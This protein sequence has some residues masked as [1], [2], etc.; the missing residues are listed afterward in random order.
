VNEGLQR[1]LTLVIAPAG[2]GKTTLVADWARQA[3]LPVAWLS[4][5]PAERAPERFL[6]YLIQTLQSV[7][8]GLGQTS[9]AL[10]KG[11]SNEA[12]LLALLNDLAELEQD[13]AL[14]LDDYHSADSPEIAEIIRLLLESRPATLHLVL[15]TRA[16]PSF[17]LAR[18]R[19]LDQLVEIEASELRFSEAELSDFLEN[20]MGV[21]LPA[22]SMDQL[23]QSM[24]GWAAGI[25]LAALAMQGMQTELQLPAGQQHIFDYLAE[26]VIRREPPVVQDFLKKTALFERFCL[27]L[28]QAVI[29][30]S[31]VDGQTSSAAELLGHVE[32]ANLFLVPL[33]AGG[34]W[35]R[36]HALFAE[37]LQKQV[38]TKAATPLYHAASIWFEKNDLV[39]HAIHYAIHAGDFERAAELIEAHYRNIQQ[40]GE[41]TA[42]VEWL[43]ALPPEIMESHPK[44]WLAKG[45]A[46][47]ISMNSV[48]AEACAQ[49]ADALIPVGPEGEVLKGE[50]MALRIMAGIFGGKVAST[51]DISTALTHLAEQDEFLHSLL[52][53]NLSM[54]YVMLGETAL[55]IDAISE[56]LRLSQSLNNPLVSIVAQVQMGEVRQ[57][58]GALGMAERVFQQTM[59]YARETLGEHT[60]LLGLPYISYAELLREWNRFEEAARYAE[61]GI[62][63]C[64]VWQPP[65]SMDGQITLARLEAAQG[66]WDEAARRLEQAMQ[67]AESSIS[68]LDDTFVCVQLVRLELLRG[69]LIKGQRWIRQY[70]LDKDISGMYYHLYEMTQ[71]VLLRAVALGLDS[72][73]AP[74]LSLCERLTALIQEAERRE[75]VTPVIEAL[76][77]QTYAYH[78][79]ARH[80]EAAQSLSRALTLGAQCDYVRIFVDEGKRLLHLLEQ[81]HAKIHAPSSYVGSLL[82]LMRQEAARPAPVPGRDSPEVSS[83]SPL[84]RREIDILALMATGKSNQEIAAECVLS[85]HTVKKHVV[86]ILS[87]MGVNNRTQAVLLGRQL[88]WIE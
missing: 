63:Y 42:L 38:T 77:L 65:A 72:D 84:T 31:Q 29:D 22:T 60:F 88:G 24:E 12:A 64:Q 26:E 10:M 47:V 46:S 61:Q 49:K 33:E 50:A 13:F 57:M 74:A 67:V 40:R 44:L 73:L 27:P 79:L 21:H 36:Y 76:I 5:Q 6:A 53:F 8:P 69:D 48:Q 86:N 11:A 4:L 83:L 54:H 85:L 17:S 82:G 1:A 20:S 62:A 43:S 25:Q 23:N 16:A 32:R 35:Y 30:A 41:Q 7:S 19:A 55:A 34:I 68:K 28:C 9:L 75:R 39:D 52:H 59:R 2:F 81:Y 14:I 70:G 3:E 37:F 51:E 45:W 15:A 18:W 56:T 87:K 78:A 80:A 58:R 66:K 71:L